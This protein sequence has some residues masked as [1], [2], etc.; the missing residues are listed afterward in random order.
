MHLAKQPSTFPAIDAASKGA[1]H[2][3]T[4]RL[5]AQIVSRGALPVFARHEF[6]GINDGFER[7]TGC[8]GCGRA[9]REGHRLVGLKNL[10]AAQLGVD[11]RQ[12]LE[13]LGLEDLLVEPC[14]DLVLFYGGKFLVIIVDVAVELKQR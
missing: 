9:R 10:Q 5:R 12:R 7:W 8:A 2:F 6:L 4:G 3:P 13:S 1:Q 11:E 14:L